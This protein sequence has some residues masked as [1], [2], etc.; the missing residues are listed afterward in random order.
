MV[1]MM[2]VRIQTFCHYILYSFSILLRTPLQIVKNYD[3]IKKFV[4]TLSVSIDKKKLPFD[5]N[6]LNIRILKCYGKFF[7]FPYLM[8]RNFLIYNP[9]EIYIMCKILIK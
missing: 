4:G 8:K 6:K 7:L 9:K 2:E 3:R 1:E 5:I